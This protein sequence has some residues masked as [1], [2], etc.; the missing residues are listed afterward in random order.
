MSKSE[1]FQEVKIRT[2]ESAT[3]DVY[4]N[5]NDLIIELMLEAEKASTQAEKQYIKELIARLVRKR[6]EGHKNPV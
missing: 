4:I 3:S 1:G 2:A 5:V 6:N